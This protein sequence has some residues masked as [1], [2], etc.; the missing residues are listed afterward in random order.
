MDGRRYRGLRNP[1]GPLFREHDPQ[2]GAN[3]VGSILEMILQAT[4]I[5]V[6][7]P[8]L[9]FLVSAQAQTK[10]EKRAKEICARHSS[11]TPGLCL[12]IA[13]EHS[14]VLFSAWDCLVG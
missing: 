12:Q 14:Q 6:F 10:E 7:A 1:T 8:N 4:C 5:Y 3:G 11:Y 9:A 13:S 2:A